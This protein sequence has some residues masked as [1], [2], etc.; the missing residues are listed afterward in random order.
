M[1]WVG[2]DSKKRNSEKKQ[3]TFRKTIWG[4]VLQKQW[5]EYLNNPKQVSERRFSRDGKC[6]GKE[7]LKMLPG[8]NLE[9]EIWVA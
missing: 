3:H 9:L 8:P 5:E 6:R 1:R 4:Q 2:K 7:G